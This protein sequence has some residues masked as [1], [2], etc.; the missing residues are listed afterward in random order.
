M[1]PVAGGI[2]SP[3]PPAPPASVVAP[4]TLPNR[5]AVIVRRKAVSIPALAERR[6][7]R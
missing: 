2:E 4:A 5:G 7:Q 6:D 3:A 1:T